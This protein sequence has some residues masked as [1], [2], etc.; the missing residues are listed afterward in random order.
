MQNGQRLRRDNIKREQLRGN[1]SIPTTQCSLLYTG[2]LSV[3][4]GQLHLFKHP[5]VASMSGA[6]GH[7]HSAQA[8]VLSEAQQCEAISNPASLHRVNMDKGIAVSVPGAEATRDR[9]FGPL[10]K[11]AITHGELLAVRRNEL[12]YRKTHRRDQ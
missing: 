8:P 7:Q 12:A 4:L 5:V 3:E 11:S 2:L 10:C 9:R 6:L 1:R